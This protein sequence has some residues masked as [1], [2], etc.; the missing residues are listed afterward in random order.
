MEL[1]DRKQG[2]E[3]LKP[4]IDFFEQFSE[5]N[6]E[7]QKDVLAFQY[8][9]EL[10][11]QGKYR[12]AKNFESFNKNPSLILVKPL[13][14][15]K[16]ASRSVM[17]G[18]SWN[19]SRE[20]FTYMTQQGLPVLA[21][22]GETDLYRWSISPMNTNFS[23]ESHD[24]LFKVEY[25]APEKPVKPTRDDWT[26][27]DERSEAKKLYAKNLSAW[28][29]KL[30]PISGAD[31]LGA[32]RAPEVVKPNIVSASYPYPNIIASSIYDSREILINALET[33]NV[34]HGTVKVRTHASDECYGFGSWDLISSKTDLE[35]QAYLACC[36]K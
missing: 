23:M 34:E 9:R 29:N 35:H 20:E 30:R 12:E 16:T 24:G 27:R 18:M 1:S 6:K 11:N 22:P 5:T 15:R 14:P 32:P 19:K 7:D 28:K 26:N 13:S 4:L 31:S 10:N 25:K 2:K 3:R 33:K 36:S 17:S 8:R 21:G